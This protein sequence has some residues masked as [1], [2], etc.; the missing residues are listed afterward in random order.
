MRMMKIS[1]A[2]LI[3]ATLAV[4]A[5]VDARSETRAQWGWTPSPYPWCAHISAPL[6]GYQECA[7]MALEQCRAT[8]S[9]VGGRCYENPAYVGPPPQYRAARKHRR[10]AR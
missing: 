1:T 8:I 9:G 10:H 6:G 7:Y 3:A 4:A 2:A 5:A